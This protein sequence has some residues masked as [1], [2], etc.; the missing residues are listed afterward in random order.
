MNCKLKR[1]FGFSVFLLTLN[2][3]IQAQSINQRQEDSMIN[4][5]KKQVMN[6]P[7]PAF[8]ASGDGGVI[9][10]DSLKG[11]VTFINMWEASCVPCMAEMGTLNKLFDTLSNYP[12]F[13]FVSL[14]ADNAETMQRIKQKYHIRFNMYH[15]DEEGCYQLNGGMGYPTSIVLDGKGRVKYIHSGGYMDSTKIWH[16]VF[17]EDIYP[18][19]LTELR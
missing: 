18:A 9:N 12:D 11:K 7:L 6:K 10:N 2:T 15:L 4:A 3:F 5:W 8:I 13:Q 1:L 17:T 16:F 19:I 14:S